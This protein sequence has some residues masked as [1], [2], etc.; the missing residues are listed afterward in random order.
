V[1]IHLDY[2]T[3]CDLDIKEVG[4]WR[5]VTHPSFRVLLSA[6]S[7]AGG[8]VQQEECFYL[9]PHG[10]D[11][12]LH[13]FNA[14]FEMAVVRAQGHSVDPSQWRCTLAH[15]YARSFSGD[16]GK[17]GEQVGIPA[18]QQKLK[19]GTRLIN[20]FCKPPYRDR[21]GEKWDRF[22]LYNRT[23]VEAERAIWQRLNEWSPWTQEE[24]AL[25]ELDRVINERGVPVDLT[26][27]EHA[28]ALAAEHRERAVVECKRLTGGIGPDQVGALFK[29]AKEHGYE[30]ETLRAE[31]IRAWL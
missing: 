30:G 12:T 4:L 23:D 14:P 3:S 8:D 27:V 1:R 7:Y 20:W 28:I 5:Y 25:W 21:T 24:Q 2:E 17:V 26:M 6:W 16:L 19:E 22:K 15:A 13:A 29:W 9:P 18:D 31:E 10:P 11:D